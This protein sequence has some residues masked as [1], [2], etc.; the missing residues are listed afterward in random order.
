[1]TEE[2]DPFFLE[3]LYGGDFWLI[4]SAVEEDLNRTCGGWGWLGMAVFLLFAIVSGLVA[5]TFG[6]FLAEYVPLG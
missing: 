6:D 5:M 1:M 4:A 3:R 2:R